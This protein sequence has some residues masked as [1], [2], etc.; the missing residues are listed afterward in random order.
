MK[1]YL[2]LIFVFAA[3]VKLNAQCYIDD[4]CPAQFRF[5]AT[6]TTAQYLTVIFNDENQCDFLD[7]DVT[8]APLPSWLS[9]S[10]D[11]ANSLI[12]TCKQNSRLSRSAEVSYV[13][14]GKTY[15]FTV[16]Q[17]AAQ[18]PLLT[19]YQDADGDGYGNA[20]V[21]QDASSMPVG[22]VDNNLDCDDNNIDTTIPS[23][24]WYKD[25][26]GD[27]LGDINDFVVQCENLP[28]PVGY[29][30][31]NLDLYPAIHSNNNDYSASESA[32][33]YGYSISN[34]VPQIATTQEDLTVLLA[35]DQALKN[36]SYYD[37]IGRPI[38][39]IAVKRSSSKK[40]IIQHIDYDDFGR[41]DKE[42]LPYVSETGSSEGA[43]RTTNQRAAIDKYYNAHFP[44]DFGSKLNPYYQKIYDNSPLNR[45][46]RQAAPGKIWKADLRHENDHTIKFNHATNHSTEVHCFIVEN[47]TLKLKS[48]G[49]HY[50]AS[51]LYKTIT[52]DE[53]WT[54]QST[55]ELDKLNTTEEFKDKQGQLVLKR[56]HVL[57]NGSSTITEQLNTYYV[58][59]NFGLLRY[60][61]PPKATN[62]YLNGGSSTYTTASGYKVIES[63]QSLNAVEAG[64]D[65]YF[66]KHDASL[67]LKPGYHFKAGPT[68]S[69]LIK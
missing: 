11:Y 38:Q 5:K 1:K 26:D 45:V 68:Q 12:I 9:V 46:V 47:N 39:D 54:D 44:E 55:D 64:T 32:S 66:V 16:E 29:V 10:V 60:V 6:E 50:T 65:K 24:K 40:D 19:F 25:T 2:I 67:S 14:D 36:T 58:Y 17:A 33:D 51:Q 48:R 7:M 52:K 59:D 42:Y 30:T 21:F 23:V 69:L 22:Y 43:F 27:G 18:S 31:N 62:M 37:G 61:L 20:K 53:N 56:S 63:N 3:F 8:I 41:Q 4:M 49:R 34:I 28:N 35:N 57:Q 15:T 13:F